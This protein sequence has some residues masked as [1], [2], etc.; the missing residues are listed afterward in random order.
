MTHIG[1]QGP[2]I[3]TASQPLQTQANNPFGRVRKRRGSIGASVHGPRA[4]ARYPLRYSGTAVRSFGD[5]APGFRCR[6]T[7]ATAPRIPRLPAAEQACIGLPFHDVK[8]L[9][10]SIEVSPRSCSSA[11][12]TMMA[13]L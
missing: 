7:R 9:S 3:L 1:L 2:A 4:F 6:S 5:A 8:Y 12:V 10:G 11:R 13:R